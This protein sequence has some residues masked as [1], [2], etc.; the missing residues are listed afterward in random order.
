MVSQVSVDVNVS[1]TVCF[2]Y[3]QSIVCQ[4]YHSKAIKKSVVC[5]DKLQYLYFI[6]FL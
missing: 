2:K 5:L 1:Q 4:L 6:P 3:V